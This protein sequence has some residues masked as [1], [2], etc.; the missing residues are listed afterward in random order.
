[1]WRA[2]DEEELEENMQ[3]GE[4]DLESGIEDWDKLQELKDEGL[5]VKL[6]ILAVDNG[7]DPR[8]EDSDDP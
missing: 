6:M 1:L 3:Q 4:G 8:D 5:F 2:D 7:D